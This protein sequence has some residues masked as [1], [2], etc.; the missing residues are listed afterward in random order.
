MRSAAHYLNSKLENPRVMCA[1][2]EQLAF[3][4]GAGLCRSDLSLSMQISAAEYLVWLA[5]RQRLLSR[6][7]MPEN[8]PS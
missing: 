6:L 5:E 8:Q 4:L 2:L 3:W 7:S 1:K